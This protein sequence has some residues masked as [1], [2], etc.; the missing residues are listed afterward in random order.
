MDFDGQGHVFPAGEQ[1]LLELNPSLE[2]VDQRSSTQTY[3]PPAGFP[4]CCHLVGYFAGPCRTG[5]LAPA[6]DSNGQSRKMSFNQK[7]KAIL[8]QSKYQFNPL[9]IRFCAGG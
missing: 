9:I 6:V 7:G 1:P 2:A 5:V 3:K 4:A 8:G